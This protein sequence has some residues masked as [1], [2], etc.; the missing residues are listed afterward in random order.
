MTRRHFLATGLAGG[1]LALG[2]DALAIEP[3]RLETTFHRLALPGL[4]PS[5]AG[6]RVVQ[7]SDLHR[8]PLVADSLIQ[9]AVDRVAALKPDLVAL[10][11]DFVSVDWRNADPC[12][13][14]M[15]ALR[16]PLGAWAVLGNHDHATNP[17][18]VA[19]ALRRHGIPVMVNHNHR[20]IS[21]LRLVGIDDTAAGH[22]DPARAF[23]GTRSGEA[24]LLLT[25]NPSL[26]RFDL[27]ARP[28]CILAGHTHG[29]QVVI[30][31]LPRHLMPGL[32]A[33]HYVAGWYRRGAHRMYVNR[34][35]GMVG[36]PVRF[37][38]RPEISVFDLQPA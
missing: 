30:P 23:R 6:L 7:I 24:T 27:P 10:T 11:G 28:L 16:P 29:G 4:S 38:C 32:R 37:L 13:E 22:P 12:V 20:L 21:G 17:I 5:L 14:M 33:A 1:T 36:L 9:A 19:R 8:G 3:R 15:A 2:T 34:G 25:H 35:V 31:G 26:L 18:E